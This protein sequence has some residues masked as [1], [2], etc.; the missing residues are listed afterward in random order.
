MSTITTSAPDSRKRAANARPIPR[1]APV[2]IAVRS[3]KSNARFVIDVISAPEGPACGRL[4]VGRERQSCL[5]NSCVIE[6]SSRGGGNC[7]RDELI[8]RVAAEVDDPQGVHRV[9]VRYLL[10]GDRTAGAKPQRG[11]LADCCNR[12]SGA[13]SAGHYEQAGLDASFNDCRH[14]VAVGTSKSA[15]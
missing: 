2:M 13:P 14:F 12:E 1:A 5:H 9:V 11:V 7:F 6:L 10:G 8:E 3:V 15:Q 4:G